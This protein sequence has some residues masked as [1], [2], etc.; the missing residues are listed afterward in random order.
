MLHSRSHTVGVAVLHLGHRVE[1]SRRS[2]TKKP[3]RADPVGFGICRRDSPKGYLVV[4][5]F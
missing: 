4:K 5:I 2:G 1:G 3:D